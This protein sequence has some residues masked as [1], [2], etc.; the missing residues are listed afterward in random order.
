[1][2]I[3]PVITKE[4]ISLQ[5]YLY[6]KEYNGERIYQIRKNKAGPNEFENILK[7]LKSGVYQELKVTIS[8]MLTPI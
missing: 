3:K 2:N 7:L 5:I 8:I 4:E 6:L 1:M